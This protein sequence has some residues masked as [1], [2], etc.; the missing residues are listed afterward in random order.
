MTML[1]VVKATVESDRDFCNILR[2]WRPIEN[3]KTCYE[4]LKTG[5]N[6]IRPILRGQYHNSSHCGIGP[7]RSRG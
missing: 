5:T 7:V 4:T 6:K 1:Y 2:V 3:H